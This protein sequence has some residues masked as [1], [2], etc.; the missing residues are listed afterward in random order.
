MLLVEENSTS[1]SPAYGI[2]RKGIAKNHCDELEM[3]SQYQS[4]RVL[5]KVS[6]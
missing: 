1:L 6:N 5:F 3:I 2:R 4:K